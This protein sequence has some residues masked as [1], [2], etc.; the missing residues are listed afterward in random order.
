LKGKERFSFLEQLKAL[1]LSGSYLPMAVLAKQQT[2][3]L[4]L[5]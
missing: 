2:V 3:D 1:S 4:Q 5:E